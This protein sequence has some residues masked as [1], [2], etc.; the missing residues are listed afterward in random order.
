MSNVYLYLSAE[1][2][3]MGNVYDSSKSYL[4]KDSIQLSSGDLG[5]TKVLKSPTLRLYQESDEGI[6]YNAFTDLSK[7]ENI[8][9]KPP[10]AGPFIENYSINGETKTEDFINILLIDKPPT[11]TGFCKFTIGAVSF[12][13]VITNLDNYVHRDWERNGSRYQYILKSD[14]LGYGIEI[15]K[16][17][18][19]TA[20]ISSNS[21]VT[22]SPTFLNTFL[23]N[24]NGGEEITSESTTDNPG[25][26][27]QSIPGANTKIS[28]SLPASLF[29]ISPEYALRYIA[30]YPDLILSLKADYKKG[31]E[32]YAKY[33]AIQGR[34]ITFDPIVYL[35]SYAD[36]RQTYGYNTTLATVHY[37]NTGYYQGR[38]VTA[39]SPYNP[40][41]GGL[42]DERKN[43][44]STT[45]NTII[46]P[47]SKTYVGD[48]KSL[49]YRYNN[50]AYYLN[51]ALELKSN[52]TYLRV[53]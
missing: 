46:W 34:T 31:Q 25:T 13:G 19:Y 4:Y 8:E 37:I 27:L 2:V 36:L 44:V 47:K 16:N 33:G 24:L 23:R 14:N 15:S 10:I 17:I 35:N 9:P 49:T 32:H 12:T 11:R 18:L 1:Q 41:P 39:G 22:Y 7:R 28:G 26:Y 43:A 38:Q 6:L 42:Y 5:F 51:E 53:Y 29:Y 52:V 30:S 21:T 48:G 45:N 3:T 40:L 50:S 20:N